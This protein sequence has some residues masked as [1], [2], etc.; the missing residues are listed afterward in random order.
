MVYNLKI[1]TYQCSFSI[2]LQKSSKHIYFHL[3]LES[4]G[5]VLILTNAVSSI[6]AVASLTHTFIASF[7]VGAVGIT[8]TDWI[9]RLTLINICKNQPVYSTR[10]NEYS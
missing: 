4:S 2:R 5:S 8:V 7:S 1:D 9:F 3:Q 10:T 6:A